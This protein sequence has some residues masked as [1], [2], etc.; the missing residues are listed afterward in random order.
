M[1]VFCGLIGAASTIGGESGKIKEYADK[2]IPAQGIVGTIL[3]LA[4]IYAIYKTLFI[5]EISFVM[6]ALLPLLIFLS[7]IGLGLV[8][9][10]D[11]ICK[12]ISSAEKMK[13]IVSQ[14]EKYKTALAWVNLSYGY[15][16]IVTTFFIEYLLNSLQETFFG[17]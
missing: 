4:S 16:G 9:G 12:K 11:F 14:L 1:M 17:F 3:S 2:L 8:L 13:G 7:G 5:M 6:W 15:L 10:F